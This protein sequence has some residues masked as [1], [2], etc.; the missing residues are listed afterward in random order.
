MNF[1]NSRTTL[2]SPTLRVEGKQGDFSRSVKG[3]LATVMVR[4]CSRAQYYL[5]AWWRYG[6]RRNPVSSGF[7]TFGTFKDE[8][9]KI[10]LESVQPMKHSCAE[11]KMA[12]ARL[13]G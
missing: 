9:D 2:V 4:V 8:P 13:L 1:G 3:V 12:A 11:M 7:E 6:T 10:Y 5:G